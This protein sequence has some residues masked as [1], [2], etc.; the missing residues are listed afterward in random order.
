MHAPRAPSPLAEGCYLS[1]PP[2]SSITFF[3]LFCFHLCLFCIILLHIYP[4]PLTTA[5][6]LWIRF[7]VI[8]LIRIQVIRLIMVRI[9]VRM[10][11][12]IWSMSL[13]E[14]LLKV[15]SRIRIKVP[16]RIR[17]CIKVTSGIRIRISVLRIRNTAVG[18]SVQ[19]TSFSNFLNIVT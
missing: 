15:M 9:N 14:N 10:R 11:A 8:S 6:P 19:C 4:V 5:S 12:E 18:C 2:S 13:F 16:S 1:H 17:I 3:V 7:K